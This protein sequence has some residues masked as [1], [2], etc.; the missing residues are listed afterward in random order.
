MVDDEISKRIK[1]KLTFLD[2]VDKIV[3]E[4]QN[5]E[6]SEK[7]EEIGTRLLSLHN[8]FCEHKKQEGV[9]SEN[10][11]AAYTASVEAWVNDVDALIEKMCKCGLKLNEI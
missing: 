6:T 11:S 4:P 9:V 2:A 7:M 1:N 5:E 3:D 10:V 8:I